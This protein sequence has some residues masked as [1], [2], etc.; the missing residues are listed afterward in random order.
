MPEFSL[1]SVLL[2][3]TG[4]AIL[5]YA[6]AWWSARRTA[7][8]ARAE[9]R[10]A[11]EPEIAALATEQRALARERD[12]LRAELEALQGAL[13]R[14]RE[15]LAAVGTERSVLIER[16][17]AE[18]RRGVEQQALL[19]QA[20]TRLGEAFQNLANR[21]LDDK[22]QRFAE[23]HGQQIT[24]LLDPLKEQLKE[25]R[26]TV[27]DTHAREQR[28]R[29]ALSAQIAQLRDL[30][31]RIS[32]DASN[33]TRALKG[34][35]RTQGAWGEMVLERVLEASGLARGREY[36]VQVAL[37]DEGGGRPRPDVI[38]RLPDGKDLVIDA[39]V[40]L[41]AYERY[42]AAVDEAERSTH[43]VE[44]A[45]SVRRHI[46]QL[47]R[48]DYSTAAGLR[49]LDMVLLFVPIEAAFI[50]AIRQEGTLYD[51]AFA[52]N[53]VLVSPSTLLATLR[54]VAHVWQMEKR[55]ANAME[56]AKRAGRLYDS[57][58]ELVRE[59]GDV[60]TQ[61]DR[62]RQS[63]DAAVK[64][65]STGKGNLM[66]RALQLRELGAESNKNFPDGALRDALE[67]GE[68]AEDDQASSTG[69]STQ[70][71]DDAVE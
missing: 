18:Q 37:R 59:L 29:G 41:T 71:R 23:Q 19:A 39:K 49:T 64:R 67:L 40:S 57:F 54:A 43:L 1:T 31:Q 47:A 61:L 50:E 3:L 69:E 51:Y 45:A 20:E 46:E 4:G 52:R 6:S 9:G 44:H 65:L 48:R 16:L 36:D 55:N 24:H 58:V 70:R 28:E 11:R 53:I 30:N 13:E 35:A 60:G 42:Y 68:S 5:G 22:T 21:I 8:A 33:L 25:F 38:V 32:Q 7:D 62:A 10:Q 63:Y 15:Q 66:R 26:Q 56:I 27:T 12:G 14:T 2:G 34:E 17:T